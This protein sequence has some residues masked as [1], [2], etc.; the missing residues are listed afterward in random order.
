MVPF[1]FFLIRQL[2]IRL[3]MWSKAIPRQES[4]VGWLHCSVDVQQWLEMIILEAAINYKL[5]NCLFVKY[6][7]EF[8]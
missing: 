6:S 3:Q 7:S 1:F 5:K 8:C 4:F 2:K